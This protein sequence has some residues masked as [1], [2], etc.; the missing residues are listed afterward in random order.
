MNDEALDN[1]LGSPVKY[2]VQRKAGNSLAVILFLQPMSHGL[3]GHFKF[4]ILLC[5]MVYTLHAAHVS[6][7]LQHLPHWAKKPWDNPDLRSINLLK[8]VYI[9]RL[10]N[11]ALTPS[12]DCETSEFSQR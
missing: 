7:V 5:F 12:H 8:G 3:P 1:F 11:P 10:L 6:R 4:C 2:N 9:L